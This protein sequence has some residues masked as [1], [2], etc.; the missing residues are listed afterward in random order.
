MEKLINGSQ[1]S[2]ETDRRQRVVLEGSASES[3]LVTSGVP[4][5]SVVG[6][7]LFSIFINDL[8]DYVSPGCCVRMF[9]DDC[10]VYSK[11]SSEEDSRHIQ[12]DLDALQMWERDWLMKFNPE[13]CQSSPHHQ[14]EKENKV[15]ILHPWSTAHH[16][17]HSKIHLCPS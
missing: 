11:I 9:A 10:M 7:M 2:W 1:T 6:P 14:Q 4:Q 5:G 16:S 8:P 13:K 12:Q 3:T 15:F 17:R